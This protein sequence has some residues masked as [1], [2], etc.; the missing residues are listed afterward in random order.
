MGREVR[1][2]PANWQHPKDKSGKYIPLFGHSFAREAANWDVESAKWNAGER[3]DYPRPVESDYMPDW[4][5]EQR[6]HFQMY[7]CTSEGTPISPV[8]ETAEQLA[9]WLVDNAASAFAGM[10][11]T[12]EQWLA[13]IRRGSA[14]SAIMAPETG[15]KMV[16]GV[17]GLAKLGTRE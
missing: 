9:R 2:V 14:P 7:E 1:M 11:A 12:Y 8:M 15:G 4:P 3:P 17:E 5:R 6:T 10:T 13:T 16:S